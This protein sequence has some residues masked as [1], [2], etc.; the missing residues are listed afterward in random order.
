LKLIG[1]NATRPKK[2]IFSGSV[3][4]TAL[5]SSPPGSSV[6]DGVQSKRCS[7]ALDQVTLWVPGTTDRARTRSLA[8]LGPAAASRAS[9]LMH[10]FVHTQPYGTPNSA[11]RLPFSGRRAISGARRND[12]SSIYKGAVEWWRRQGVFIR[13]YSRLFCGTYFRI[14]SYPD[15]ILALPFVFFRA[16]SDVRR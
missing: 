15:W 16:E 9:A 12:R 11:R 14:L 1:T 13:V 10:P 6:E 7:F 4:A 2:A 8:V 3:S 5:R